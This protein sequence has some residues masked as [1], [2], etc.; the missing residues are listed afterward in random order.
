M[1]DLMT[2]APTKGSPRNVWI[3]LFASPLRSTKAGTLAGLTF[4][5][6]ENIDVNLKVTTTGSKAFAFTAKSDAAVVAKLLEEPHY[7]LGYGCD[8]YSGWI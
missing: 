2:S 7:P 8:R 6:K 4:A 3:D 1:K 5:V